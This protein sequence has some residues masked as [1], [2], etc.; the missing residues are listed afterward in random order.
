ML[1]DTPANATNELGFFG[2]NIFVV[3]PLVLAS[4]YDQ[5]QC[6]QY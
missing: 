5:I 2:R 6:H 1:N 3:L 4:R